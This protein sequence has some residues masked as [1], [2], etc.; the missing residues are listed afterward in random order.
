MKLMKVEIENPIKKSAHFLQNCEQS[1]IYSTT[2][3]FAGGVHAG[4][5]KQKQQIVA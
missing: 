2:R 1:F 3:S 4:L 5:L